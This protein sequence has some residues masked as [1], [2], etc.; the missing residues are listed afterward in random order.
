MKKYIIY[1]ICIAF[2]GSCTEDFAELNT[3]PDVI[4]IPPINSVLTYV[5]KKIADSKGS[6]WYYTNHQ[7]MPWCQYLVLDEANSGDVDVLQ[8]KDGGYGNLYNNVLPHLQEIRRQ[9]EIMP[10]EQQPNYKKIKA[11]TYILE[12][13]SALRMTDYYG[14][15]PYSE[16]TMGRFEGK[17]DPVY[18]D[19]ETLFDRFI[20]DLNSSITDLSDN[21]T[22]QVELVGDK[23]DFIYKGD[24]LKWLKCANAIK[25]RIAT[26]LETADLAKAKTIISSVATDGRLFEGTE[27]Q[28][29]WE[30][31]DEFRGHGGANFEWKGELWSSKPLV[32]F[33]KKTVDPRIRIFFEPNGFNQETLDVYTNASE[34][35]PPVIDVVNDTTLL[36]TNADGEEIYAYRYIG[37]PADRNAENLSDYNYNDEANS[38]GLNA[39]Q[40][41]KWNH[42]FLMNCNTDIGEGKATGK[43]VDALISYA[44]V[45]FLMSEYILKNYIT[46]GDAKDWYEKGVRASMS[47]YD[48]MATKQK[49]DVRMAGEI[50]RYLP[51]MQNEIDA[52]LAT[53]EVMFDGV[54]DIE[55][56]YI[57]QHI[58]FFKLPE[59]GWANAKRTGYPKYGSSLLARVQIDNPE[60]KLPRR[61]PTP[62][63]GDLNRS[64][65][66]AANA[67]QGF[68]NLDE[69]PAVLNAQRM[70][71]D[72][73]NPNIGAGN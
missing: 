41:S 23:V 51:I 27:D 63:P 30:F 70:W 39:M 73:S 36:Y 29:L 11:I 58:N 6:E 10:E 57:Q 59:E 24:W 5:E 32:D 8:P 34:P 72:E 68:S 22:P 1:L 20:T 40:L 13:Y 69:S 64:N 65:W 43:Y 2:L 21:T 38:T 26:R 15:I 14:S 3:N 12:V 28:F 47:T 55:K 18:D 19:Q 53:P 60:L 50:L 62:E 49:V 61:V 4:E 56:V 54:N 7:I 45:C 31:S 25:L 16:A 17:L 9:I 52:Y 33:M 66:E 46:G 71:W 37:V 48:Y 44:E 35:F 67:A 42:R